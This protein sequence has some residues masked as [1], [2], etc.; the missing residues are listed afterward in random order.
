MKKS[1]LAFDSYFKILRTNQAV[2]QINLEDDSYIDKED[3]EAY[4]KAYGKKNYVNVLVCISDKN[5][6]STMF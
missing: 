1:C 6:R 4:N 2:F 3:E 5:K